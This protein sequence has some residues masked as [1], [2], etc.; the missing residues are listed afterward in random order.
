MGMPLIYKC[1]TKTCVLNLN[2]QRFPHEK[3]TIRKL[4][5]GKEFMQEE[6]E[7]ESDLEKEMHKLVEVPEDETEAQRLPPNRGVLGHAWGTI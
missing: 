1:T 5:L 4:K 7:L 2:D 6:L 3:D